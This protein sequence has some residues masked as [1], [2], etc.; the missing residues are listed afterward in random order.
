MARKGRASLSRAF[1]IIPIDSRSS[2]SPSVSL[3]DRLE[4]EEATIRDDFDEIQ[5]LAGMDTVSS[6]ADSSDLEAVTLTR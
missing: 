6:D 4:V 5:Q 1:G 3:Q 2:T